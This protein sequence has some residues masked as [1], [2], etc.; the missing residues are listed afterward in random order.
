M[1]VTIIL[2]VIGAFGKVTI[3]LL[4]GMDDFEIRGRVE[5]VQITEL[6]R[7]ARILRRALE[8][9]GDLLLRKLQQKNDQLKLT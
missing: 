8:T 6:L 5:T 4:K 3:G 9:L 2:I 7:L 1:K